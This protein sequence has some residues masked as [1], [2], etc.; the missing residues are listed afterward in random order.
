MRN[1][2]VTMQIPR[3]FQNIPKP[4]FSI[5]QNKKNN[6]KQNSPSVDNLIKMSTIHSQVLFRK[7]LLAFSKRKL[8]ITFFH[9]LLMSVSD[10]VNLGCAWQVT[11]ADVS[12]FA[13]T[14]EEFL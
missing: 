9:A 11:R 7:M 8:F 1:I 5:S 14:L 6:K 13:K 3:Y 4:F 2:N 12:I 10:G